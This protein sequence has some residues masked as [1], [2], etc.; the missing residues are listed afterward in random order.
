VKFPYL[1]GTARSPIPSLGGT[2][3]RPRPV[4]AVRV[5][6][7]TRARLIDGL[8]DTGSDDTVFE[9]SVALSIG[10]DLNR[11]TE[12]QIGLVGRTRP[13]VCRYAQVELCLTD[14]LSETYVWSAVVGFVANKTAVCVIRLRGLPAIL[15]C[16]VSRGCAHA[17]RSE[18]ASFAIEPAVFP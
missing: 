10:V 12:R 9:E 8:F 3:V 13:V 16:R 18:N 4:Y 5:A 14:G 15:R 11:A 1:A 17:E 7:P 6:G 2:V